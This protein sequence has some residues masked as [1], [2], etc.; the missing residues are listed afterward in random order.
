MELYSKRYQ[1]CQITKHFQRTVQESPDG[2]IQQWYRLTHSKINNV[3]DIR[4]YNNH[5]RNCNY[6]WNNTYQRR[7]TPTKET[8]KNETKNKK[9]EKKSEKK[10]RNLKHTK[11]YEN[12]QGI[13]PVKSTWWL[14][15]ETFF[16]TS[17]MVLNINCHC[18][19]I[20]I[21]FNST[22]LNK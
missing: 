18:S 7:K 14:F 12:K 4:R 3:P 8:N 10:K 15:L 19:S 16:A 9:E 5:K 13:Q 17:N 6:K 20:S 11:Q 1:N 21:Y 2:T 22:W